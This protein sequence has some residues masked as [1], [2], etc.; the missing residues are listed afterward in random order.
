[1]LKKTPAPWFSL[2]AEIGIAKE[3][4]TLVDGQENA[5]TPTHSQ[6]VF[7]NVAEQRLHKSSIDF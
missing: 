1:M 3:E 7:I 5:K 2:A 6:V 4:C